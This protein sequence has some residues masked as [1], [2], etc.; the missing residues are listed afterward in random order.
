MVPTLRVLQRNWPQ[1]R[2]TWIIGKA[3][4]SLL[5]DIP[6]V[7]FIVYDKKSGLKGMLAL[8]RQLRGRQFDILL[9]MQAAFRA[10][11]LSLFIPA[12]RR[13]GF[14]KG[15]AKDFQQLFAREYI[16][17]N[18]NSHV[19]EGYLD[20]TRYLGAEDTAPEWNIPIPLADEQT[21]Q[22]LTTA[23]QPYLLLSPCSSNR[24]RNWRNW[25]VEGYA[26]VVQYAYEKYGLHTV[27]TGGNS[28]E[29]LHYGDSLAKHSPDA[30]LNLVGKTSLKELLALVKHS[31]AVIA[32]DSGPV[33]MAVAFQKPA[34]GLYVTSDPARS[35]P[36]RQSQWV[37]NY[38]PQA[39][40]KYLNKTPDQV[41]F[42][43]RVRDPD[44]MN[45]IPIEAVTKK[46]DL[47][48][49]HNHNKDN[50]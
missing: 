34:I 27:I 46:I 22:Q 6:G 3:E 14:D 8:K 36:W 47:L 32:P 37:V 38:Y 11:V 10:S 44:A 20:F 29:E 26:A 9:H 23:K 4:H 21:A 33:H 5:G 17:S 28:D 13:I 48:M 31:Q 30:T 50:A 7:E 18:P 1:A 2:I 39:L 42:G 40:K 25:S 24:A 19:A 43:Q 35:G 49:Q 16:P 41:S 12:K 45:I 15:R